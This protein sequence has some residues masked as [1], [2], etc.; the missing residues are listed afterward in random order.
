MMGYERG[1]WG[2]YCFWFL[3]WDGR[4]AGMVGGFVATYLTMSILLPILLMLIVATFIALASRHG[5]KH[6]PYT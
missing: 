6:P 2:L 4:T 5:L 1:V 3:G